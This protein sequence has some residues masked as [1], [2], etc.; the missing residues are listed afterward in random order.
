MRL[1]AL[2]LVLVL[3]TAAAPAFA[4]PV[5][6]VVMI[7]VSASMAPYFN[8]VVNYFID[9]LMRNMLQTGDRFDLIT[10]AGLPEV[11]MSGVRIDDRERAALVNRIPSAC[12]P[13]WSAR[14]SFSRA[15]C[16]SFRPRSPASL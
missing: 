11:Q 14:S 16:R 3:A 1:A 12:T 9:D 6:L 10:F 8:D 5:E 7:D 13:T 2:A 15:T 4:E